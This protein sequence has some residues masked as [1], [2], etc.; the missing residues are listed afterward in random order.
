MLYPLAS[1]FPLSMHW[2]VQCKKWLTPEVWLRE[3][4]HLPIT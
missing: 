3:L 1:H 2:L 4:E